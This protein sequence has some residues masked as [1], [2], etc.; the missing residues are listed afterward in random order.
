MLSESPQL[1]VTIRRITFEADGQ[2]RVECNASYEGKPLDPFD[3]VIKVKD[4]Y[5]K[6]VAELCFRSISRSLLLDGPR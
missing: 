1:G 2:I 3:E 4:P 5:S 6:T